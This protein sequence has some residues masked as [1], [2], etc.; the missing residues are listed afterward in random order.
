MGVRREGGG[1][2]A[3]GA[4]PGVCS[5]RFGGLVSGDCSP[6][7]P[8]VPAMVL[9]DTYSHVSLVFH[10]AKLFFVCSPEHHVLFFVMLHTYSCKTQHLTNI[11]FEA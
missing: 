3:A 6:A 5:C 9:L 1:T 11:T 4:G 10:D 7:H 8:L 2:G